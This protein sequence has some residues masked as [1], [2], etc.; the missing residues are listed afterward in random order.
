MSKK[1]NSFRSKYI[2]ITYIRN[3][4]ISSSP[5]CCKQRG[6]ALNELDVTSEL[7]DTQGRFC[8]FPRKKKK[9][10]KKRYSATPN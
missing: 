4:I 5:K 6:E 1:I 3:P 2:L 9:K 10:K 7:C 8:Q